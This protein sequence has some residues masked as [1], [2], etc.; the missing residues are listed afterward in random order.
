MVTPDVARAK[1]TVPE[2][3]PPV[4]PVPAVTPVMSPGFGAAHSSPVAVAELILRTYPL[5]A[6]TDSSAGVDAALAAMIEP[7]AVTTVF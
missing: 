6:A 1:V 4:K 2:S 5:V 3:P 7:F